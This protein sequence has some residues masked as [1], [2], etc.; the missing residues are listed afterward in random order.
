MDTIRRQPNSHRRARRG[1]FR[2]SPCADWGRHAQ[3]TRVSTG[4]RGLNSRRVLSSRVAKWDSDRTCDPTRTRTL[5]LKT[6]VEFWLPRPSS[7]PLCALSAGPRSQ[8][9]T[10]GQAAYLSVQYEVLRN[11]PHHQGPVRR[12]PL[13]ISAAKDAYPVVFR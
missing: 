3:P 11:R 13:V 6:R 8:K 12:T 5:E 7:G 9:W 10:A 1:G 2:R 4:W